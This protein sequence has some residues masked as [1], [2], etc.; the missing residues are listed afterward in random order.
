VSLTGDTLEFVDGIE[1]SN[2][3]VCGHV[4]REEES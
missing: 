4:E 2:I 1:E 3:V